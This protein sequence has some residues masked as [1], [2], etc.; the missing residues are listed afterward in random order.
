MVTF[1]TTK[2]GFCALMFHAMNK[3]CCMF[4]QVHFILSGEEEETDVR[5]FT[6]KKRKIFQR[7]CTNGFLMAVTEYVHVL[8]FFNSNVI[9]M[10]ITCA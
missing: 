2:S 8:K 10:Y 6:D 5:T 9:G 3:F 1:V 4:L 7:G